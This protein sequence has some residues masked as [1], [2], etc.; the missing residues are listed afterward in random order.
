VRGARCG[1]LAACA[2]RALPPALGGR[3]C[4]AH[5]VGGS[6]FRRRFWHCHVPGCP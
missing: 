6:D 3:R 4:E 2:G 1:W 5:R